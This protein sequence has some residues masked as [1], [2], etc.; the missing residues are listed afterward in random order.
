VDFFVGDFTFVALSTV[1]DLF[2]F[3]VAA[4]AAPD[5]A[6]DLAVVALG[7][8]G[9]LFGFVVPAALVATV[10]L[11][12]VA[13]FPV[14]FT[15]FTWA[16]FFAAAFAGAFFLAAGWVGVFFAAMVMVSDLG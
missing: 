14:F 13:F 3:E 8:A 10:F 12:E 15:G 5:S 2:V 4:L 1:A 9:V 7:F 11:A 16:V 6:V